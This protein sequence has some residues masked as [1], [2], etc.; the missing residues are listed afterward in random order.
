MNAA[1]CFLIAMVLFVVV[2]LFSEAEFTFLFMLLAVLSA[3]MW[4]HEVRK[5]V[6]LEDALQE[7]V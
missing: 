1:R 3:G 6:A 2:A 7:R 4:N 5:Q